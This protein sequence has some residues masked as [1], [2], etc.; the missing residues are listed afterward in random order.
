MSEKITIAGAGLAGSL[1]AILLAKKGFQVDIIERRPDMRRTTISAGRSIN[2][3]LSNRGL[4]ALRMVEMDDFIMKEV[5][6][7]KG[8]LVHK[9]DG[10]KDLQKYSGR[11]GNYINSVS[12]GGLNK[13]LMD[14]AESYSNVS[15]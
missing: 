12:R 2:L 9:K 10:T 8:R 4:R 5:V 11:E 3:A 15:F 7:M 1:L 13:A 14:K 6:P